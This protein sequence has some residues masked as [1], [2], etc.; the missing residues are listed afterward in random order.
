MDLDPRPDQA[1]FVTDHQEANKKLPVTKEKLYYFLLS[2]GTF[3]LLFKD[4]NSKRSHK[5]I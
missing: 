4:K 1:I 2:E 3:A 5:T